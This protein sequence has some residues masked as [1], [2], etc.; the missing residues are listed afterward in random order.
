MYGV[1][2]LKNNEMC[3]GIFDTTL[4]LA[5]FFKTTRNTISPYMTRKNLRECRYQ[6]IKIEGDTDEL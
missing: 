3:I 1:Y 2:D 5:N 4:E 6:I